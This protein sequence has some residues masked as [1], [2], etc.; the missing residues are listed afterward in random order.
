[1]GKKEMQWGMSFLVY[2]T[3]SSTMSILQ[4][5]CVMQ[6]VTLYHGIC[7]GMQMWCARLRNDV[8]KMVM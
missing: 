8:I 5:A 3:L 7:K 6:S 4:Y 2:F 1:M